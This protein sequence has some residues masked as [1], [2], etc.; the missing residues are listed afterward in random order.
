MRPPGPDDGAPQERAQRV[1]HAVGVDVR[2]RELVEGV[3]AAPDV[4]QTLA[5]RVDGIETQDGEVKLFIGGITVPLSAVRDVR[6][7]A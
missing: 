6:R 2:D 1:L 5:G 7:A 3:A 4:E